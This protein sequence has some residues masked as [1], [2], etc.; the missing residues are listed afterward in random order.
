VINVR[1]RTDGTGYCDQTALG[2]LTRP[3]TVSVR[4][5]R[6]KVIDRTEW[7]ERLTFAMGD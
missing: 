3:A 4:S 2:V 1:H 7:V 6:A 5:D